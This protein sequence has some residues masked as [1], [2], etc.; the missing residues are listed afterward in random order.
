VSDEPPTELPSS[1][2]VLQDLEDYLK[3]LRRENG[4]PATD[5]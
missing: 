5:N 3:S 2:V 4:D 1:A